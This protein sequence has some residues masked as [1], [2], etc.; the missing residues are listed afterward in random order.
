M[1]V[2][3]LVSMILTLDRPGEQPLEQGLNLV[4]HGRRAA[5]DAVDQIEH[6]TLG[7]LPDRP[8]APGG[9]RRPQEPLGP[10]D[11]AMAVAHAVQLQVLRGDLGE[12]VAARR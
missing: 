7:D 1:P 4:S 12:P 2:S 8:V 9:E 3:G 6:V 11:A 10:G 5:G